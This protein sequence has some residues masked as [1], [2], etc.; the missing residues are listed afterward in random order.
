M[1]N[2]ILEFQKAA[3]EKLDT[4]SAQEAIERLCGGQPD[5]LYLLSGVS[6]II[7]PETGEKRYKPGS[8]KDV[9]WNGYMTGGK[10]RALAIVELAK[11]FPNAVV[12]VNSSTF[13][14]RNPEA[15]TDADVMAEYIEHLGVPQERIM[16]QDRST[17]TF[18]ELIELIKYIAEN[19]WNH[20]V[21]MAG[22]TQKP[23]AEEML[24]QI[25]TLQDPANAWNEADFR[26]ALEEIKK[27]DPKITF[28]SAEDVLPFR[29]GRYA[30]L[31]TEA[32]K[33]DTWKARE[34]LD[35]KAVEDLKSG[36]YWK[37]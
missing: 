20:V 32:R 16:K 31:I 4:L 33:S 23:R 9:D 1:T 6:E 8:Y 18:T 28:V 14:V 11:R 22:E 37:K 26:A 7:D 10:G 30:A 12:A 3:Q 34:A 19:R 27:I 36:M 15:P 21:V 5:A 17:T 35:K 13:N 25:E 29:D 24:R 2:E